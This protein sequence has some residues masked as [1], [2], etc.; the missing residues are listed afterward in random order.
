MLPLNGR[1]LLIGTAGN[2]CVFDTISN[3]IR[4]S[5]PF[6]NC[7][8]LLPFKGRLDGCIVALLL[9]AHSQNYQR[10][11]S[12]IQV[13][14]LNS[15]NLA[16]C[17]TL[18]LDSSN[19][20]VSLTPAFAFAN[21]GLCAQPIRSAVFS[22]ELRRLLLTDGASLVSVDVGVS[23]ERASLPELAALG[24]SLT[25][26]AAALRSVALKDGAVLELAAPLVPALPAALVPAVDGK[27]SLALLDSRSGALHRLSEP[28]LLGAAVQS[29]EF[30]RVALRATDHSKAGEESRSHAQIAV[31]SQAGVFVFSLATQRAPAVL[32]V[33]RAELRADLVHLLRCRDGRIGGLRRE[34]ESRAEYLAVDVEEAVVEDAQ[35]TSMPAAV[36]RSAQVVAEGLPA[37]ETPALLANADGS[38]LAAF[39]RSARTAQLFEVECGAAG[40]S[41]APR[42][43]LNGVE[44]FAWSYAR[45]KFATIASGAIHI[46]VPF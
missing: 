31:G 6:L 15:Q 21:G 41:L 14:A 35:D 5:V 30:R 26:P 8:F 29:A 10:A 44:G 27:N 22:A 1:Y 42:R 33:S 40:V 2:L 13:V 37:D 39:F 45:E 18:S 17:W 16:I 46:Q 3:A 7:Q 34:S 28:S 11:G 36:R 20:F 43:T 23:R 4:D 38:W 19:E 25:L 32:R 9:S 12:E 24:V